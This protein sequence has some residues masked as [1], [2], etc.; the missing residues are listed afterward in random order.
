MK[1]EELTNYVSVRFSSHMKA[2]VGDLARSLKLPVSEVV[3]RAV[4]S[5]LPVWE[6]NGKRQQMPG[7]GRNGEN[8]EA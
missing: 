1:D 2:R 3:R 6:K 4:E 7:I 5:Q 8:M